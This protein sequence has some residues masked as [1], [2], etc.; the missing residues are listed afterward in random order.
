MVEQIKVNRELRK[1]VEIKLTDGTV[2]SGPRWT[3]VS[4][5]MAVYQD[6]KKPLIVGAIVDHNLRELTFP[7]SADATVEPIAYVGYGWGANLSTIIDF[8][9]RS[10]LPGI[11][12]RLDVDY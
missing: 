2:M 1:T 9:I 5:F 11:V 4:D 8:S 3:P 12:F 10:S 7:I 6:P